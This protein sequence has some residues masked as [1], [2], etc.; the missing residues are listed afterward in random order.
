[1]CWLKENMLIWSNSQS[2]DLIRSWGGS[3]EDDWKSIKSVN[4]IIEIIEIKN[5]IKGGHG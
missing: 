5:K 4:Q 1:M 3:S 2:Y